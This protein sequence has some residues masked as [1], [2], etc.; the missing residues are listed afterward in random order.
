MRF[1]IYIP[2]EANIYNPNSPILW[3]RTAV[4]R[5]NNLKSPNNPHSPR[6]VGM[7]TIIARLHRSDGWPK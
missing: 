4:A 2:I 1:I 7:V 5:N 6:G 3:M